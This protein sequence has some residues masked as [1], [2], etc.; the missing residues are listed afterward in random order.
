MTKIYLV[1]HCE[2]EG[3]LYRRMQG[4]YNS[5]LTDLGYR[6][7]EALGQRFASIPLDAVYSS[8]LYRAMY[9][10]SALCLPKKLPLHTDPRLR[11]ISMGPWEDMPF[12]EAWHSEYEE[13]CRFYCNP[14]T[15]NYPGAETYQEIS[16]RGLEALM[17][18]IQRHPNQSVAVCAH[19][20]FIS[21]MLCRLF[22]DFD[23]FHAVGKSDNT[24]VSLLHYENGSFQL[25]FKNDSSHLSALHMNRTRWLPPDGTL[26]ELY[27]RP[28]GRNIDQYIQ[29]RKDAWQVVYGDLRDFDGSGFW[30]DAQ[31]TIGPDPN[32]LVVGYLGSEPVGCIQLSPHRDDYRGVGYIPFIYLREPFRHKGLGIQFIGH[33][34]SFYRA[35]DRKTLQ[36]SVAHTNEKALGFYHKFGFRQAG[37]SPG[38]YGKL[39]LMEKDISIPT[40]PR[41]LKIIRK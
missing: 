25:V 4:Q 9:T 2:A 5:R 16:R 6:Q 36:L 19:G 28:M 14:P 26:P 1:R 8:D 23:N 39:I 41:K 11:E 27:F 40:L 29:Y 37:K 33:A 38:R 24:A 35:R 13:M 18:I 30:M 22:Y 34:V 3:N 31:R 20:Y 7:A 32:A 17:E 10:A 15:W 21:S 12:G